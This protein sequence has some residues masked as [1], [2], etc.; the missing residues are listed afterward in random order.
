MESRL[1]RQGKYWHQSDLRRDAPVAAIKGPGRRVRVRRPEGD[2]GGV[3]ADGAA[4]SRPALLG[5]LSLLWSNRA[6]VVVAGLLRRSSG[7]R[8]SGMMRWNQSAVELK[9]S[10]TT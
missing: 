1:H 6:G 7:T 5:R 2:D 10:N 8:S 9:P 3:D 4:G